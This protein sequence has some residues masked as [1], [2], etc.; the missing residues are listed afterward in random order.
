LTLPYD[1][2]RRH[3]R[4]KDAKYAGIGRAL[5]P[6]RRLGIYDVIQGEGG[7]IVFPV[8]WPLSKA[9][10]R[11]STPAQACGL[12]EIS[13]F[14]T[15]RARDGESG[16]RSRFLC[17]GLLADPLGAA[18]STRWCQGFFPPRASSG[19]L[20]GGQADLYGLLFVC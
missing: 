6:R 7:P 20:L 16:P 15:L 8:P 14:I 1:D 5:K 10:C 18:A 12:L 4:R 11:L 13:G 19:L 9:F 2:P 3:G 17:L